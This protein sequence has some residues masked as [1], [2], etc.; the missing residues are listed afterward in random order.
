[1][2]AFLY[3]PLIS[4]TLDCSASRM[5]GEAF[6]EDIVYLILSVAFFAATLGMAMLFERLRESK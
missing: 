3:A 2:R 1:M 5:N 6:M 4:A